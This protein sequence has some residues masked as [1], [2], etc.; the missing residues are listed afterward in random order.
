MCFWT[1]SVIPIPV[2]ITLN[3][4]TIG[5]FPS[6]AAPTL[7]EERDNEGEE[8]EIGVLSRR[9]SGKEKALKSLLVL[10]LLGSVEGGREGTGRRG[11]EE[12]EDD[13]R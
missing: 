8:E 13:E 11:E 9:A 4:S 12:G 3:S 10:E 5:L 1:S 6:E 2:S 7:E